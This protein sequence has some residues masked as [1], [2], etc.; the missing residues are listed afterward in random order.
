[1]YYLSDVRKKSTLC[2]KSLFLEEEEE[3]VYHSIKL[4]IQCT[5]YLSDVRQKYIVLQVASAD[6]QH[7]VNQLVRKVHDMLKALATGSVTSCM[8]SCSLSLRLL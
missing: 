1:M 2:F 3:E 4:L 7:E 5:Y 8:L 6:R